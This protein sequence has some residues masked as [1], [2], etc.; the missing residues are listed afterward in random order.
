MPTLP[1]SVSFSGRLPTEIDLWLNESLVGEVAAVSG[2]L[3]AKEES[4]EPGLPKYS[5]PSSE[6]K[7]SV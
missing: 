4:S 5:L 6:E 1:A 3:F 2:L 7:I